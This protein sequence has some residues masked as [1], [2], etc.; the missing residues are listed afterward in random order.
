[1]KL[2]SRHAATPSSFERH[3]NFPS[4]KPIYWNGIAESGVCDLIRYVARRAQMNS[5]GTKPTG[6]VPQRTP[7]VSGDWI[8]LE[9][10][11]FATTVLTALI[12][13]VY[14]VNWP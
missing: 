7:P 4:M 6:R 8:K 2:T 14:Y 11:L 12:A 5:A 1:M 3:W 9:S 10:I 13:L